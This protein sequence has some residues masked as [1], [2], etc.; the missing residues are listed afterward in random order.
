MPTRTSTEIACC[1]TPPESSHISRLQCLRCGRRC[2]GECLL[3]LST[4]P[5]C[6]VHALVEIERLDLS[7]AWW[8]LLPLIEVA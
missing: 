6:G 1:E 3:F 8:H 7:Q 4:C 2:V 5:S